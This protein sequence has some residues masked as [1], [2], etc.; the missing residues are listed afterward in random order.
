MND[1]LRQKLKDNLARIAEAESKP[2]HF[3]TLMFHRALAIGGM[4]RMGGPEAAGPGGTCTC[5]KCGA[6][7]PHGRGVP[8]DGMTCPECGAVMGRAAADGSDAETED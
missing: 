1:T 5:S 4:G 7:F 8:C 3:E 2:T 6:E